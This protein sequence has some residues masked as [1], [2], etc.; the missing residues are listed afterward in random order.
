MFILPQVKVADR[1]AVSTANAETQVVKPF[2]LQEMIDAETGK[3]R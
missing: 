2:G 1:T 3:K